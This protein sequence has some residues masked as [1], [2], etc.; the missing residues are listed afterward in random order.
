MIASPHHPPT[1]QTFSVALASLHRI[2][3]VPAL[4][5][6][7]R[8]WDQLLVHSATSGAARRT[9]VGKKASMS[10]QKEE[11]EEVKEDEKKKQDEKTK[12]KAKRGEVARR[13]HS[14][15]ASSLLRLALGVRDRSQVWRALKAVSGPFSSPF[16]SPSSSP[17]SFSSP[18]TAPTQSAFSPALFPRL[19]SSSSSPS[20]ETPTARRKDINLASAISH[21]LERLLRAPVDK[22]NLSSEES[23]VELKT[24]LEAWDAR[25]STFLGEPSPSSSAGADEPIGD[26][27]RRRAAL[28]LKSQDR[29]RL[30]EQKKRE[31]I[32][33]R[34]AIGKVGRRE[35]RDGWIAK[36][37]NDWAEKEVEREVFGRDPR[38]RVPERREESGERPFERRRDNEGGERQGRERREEGRGNE[39]RLMRG[40]SLSG[41]NDRPP[42]FDRALRPFSS[43][44]DNDR[45]SR[46]DRPPRSFSYSD[47]PPRS[48]SSSFN[49][50]NRSDRSDRPPRP[51]YSDRS[52][53]SDR[54]PYSDRS[55]DRLDRERRSFTKPGRRERERDGK[56][57]GRGGGGGGGSR[58]KGWDEE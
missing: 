17:L 19:A 23:A 6:G 57:E 37:R 13:E 25:L 10:E 11:G 46:S 9:V 18:P 24:G 12:E 36:A 16:P 49:R 34:A 39:E 7:L 27:A 50:A 58:Q 4:A 15:A 41:N 2:G 3:T 43:S 52:E 8:V 33:A 32:A 47:R 14:A 1:V 29:R 35:R 42:R 26:M 40:S 45:P 54:P 55:S 21:S 22:F 30:A 5:A 38:G 44:Y 31:Y 28:T 48:S 56:Y 51:S 20:R 53:R